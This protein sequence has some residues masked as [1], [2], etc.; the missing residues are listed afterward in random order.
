M[1]GPPSAFGATLGTHTKPPTGGVGMEAAKLQTPYQPIGFV[2]VH[3]SG[4]AKDN[5]GA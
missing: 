4:S 2:T 1:K 5:G 3:R